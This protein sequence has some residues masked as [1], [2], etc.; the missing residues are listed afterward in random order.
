MPS[1]KKI[2]QIEFGLL[3]PREIRDT[4]AR[5]IIWA[6]TY[7][8]DGFPYPQGLMDL[9]L[10]VIDPGLRCK[11]CDQKVSECPGHFGHIELAKPVIHVGYARLIRK[12]LR[13]TC[14][15]CGRLLLHP[16]ELEL[17]TATDD[18]QINDTLDNHIK[19]GHYCPHC[20][21]TQFK[22]NFEM[23]TT[24]SEVLIEDRTKVEHKLTPADIRARLEKIPNEDL[25]PLGINPDV[26][27]PEWMVLTVLPVPPV[28]MRPSIILENG[29]RS[30]DDLTHKLV[31]IIRINQ[32]FKENQDAGAPQLVMEDLWELLQ[33]HVTTY[34]DNEVTGCP[35]ARHRSGRPLKTLSQRLKGKDGRFRGSL[36]GKRVNFSSRTVISPDPNLS[37]SQVGVPRVVANEMTIPVRVTVY[38]IEESKG[39]ARNGP[40]RPDVNAPCGAN[41]VIRPDTRRLRLGADNLDIV[42]D[43]IEPGWTVERHLQ[44]GDIVLLNRQ[45]SLHRM[46]ILAHRVKIMEGRTFRLNPAACPPYNANFDGGEMNMHVPQTE[47]ARAE[48]EILISV[49][50]NIMSPRFGGPI[51]GGIHDHVSGIFMLTHGTRWLTKEETLYLLRYSGVERMPEPGKI[52]NGVEYWSNKQVFSQILPEHFNMVFHANSCQSCD[53]CKKMLCYRDAYVRIIDGQL[54]SGTIDK[55]AIG[56]FDG[57]I[58]NRIIQEQGKQRAAKFI[59]DLTKLSIRAI[60][61]DGLSF[62]IDDTDLTEVLY[63]QNNEVLKNAAL[64]VDQRIKIYD[65]GQLEPMPGRTVEETLA[66][67]ILQVLRKACD[68]TGQ[69][70][71]RHFNLENSAVLMA[72][73][74]ARGSM[75]NLAQIS[76]CLGQQTVRGE[77]LVYGY[78]DRTLSHF[79]KGD[80]GAVAHGFIQHSF[81]SGLNPTEFFFHSMSGR[82]G[83]VDVA[84][85]SAHSGY[86][87]RR[88]IY[89]LQD[90]KVEYDGT[91]RTQGGRIVQFDYGE[92][93]TDPA[94]SAFGDAV[95]VKSIVESIL[96]HDT[97]PKTEVTEPVNR[98]INQMSSHHIR[99]RIIEIKYT[100]PIEVK[101]VVPEKTII[102]L[103]RPHQDSIRP[104]II[105]E[106]PIRPTI[107]EPDKSKRCQS[108]GLEN[109][110]SNKYCSHCGTKFIELTTEPSVSSVE[111]D[112]KKKSGQLLPEN[113]PDTDFVFIENAENGLNT[114]S[115]DLFEDEVI[116]NPELLSS[117]AIESDQ[118]PESGISS[119]PE[120]PPK[121]P[122]IMAGI[123]VNSEIPI[124]VKISELHAAVRQYVDAKNY[125]EAVRCCEEIIHLDEK[126]AVAWDK[127]GHCLEMAGHFDEAFVCYDIALACN[128]DL[129]SAWFHKG[130]WFVYNGNYD[131]FTDAMNCFDQ[132]IARD[133]EFERVW[134]KKGY[135]FERLGQHRE[136]I[137]CLEKSLA[138]D[139]LDVDVWISKAYNHEKLGELEYAVDCYDLAL[140]QRPDDHDIWTL[141]GLALEKQKKLPEARL[142]FEKARHFNPGHDDKKVQSGS[143]PLSG[144]GKP[145]DSVPQR[146]VSVSSATM[147]PDNANT[148]ILLGFSSIKMGK[149]ED[150][151]TYFNQALNMDPNNLDPWVFKFECYKK[152]SMPLEAKECEKHIDVQSFISRAS[153]FYRAR[154]FERS[155]IHFAAIIQV[156]PA[157]AGL[158]ENLGLCYEKLGK[159]DVAESY[160]R[161]AK[162]LDDLE[163]AREKELPDGGAE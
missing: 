52:E 12:L 80:R 64:I 30:E 11:T 6:D 45:P 131:N 71:T 103:I 56:A 83:L 118:T 87:Q 113:E 23:P 85:R 74:G 55:K 88:M 31:D 110:R 24:F 82:E 133:P 93:G 60:M 1:P 38:N 4:S 77:R 69:I 146:T 100:A 54:E 50:E 16:L 48:A 154:D 59:D 10:G 46:S 149:Y 25:I 43:M 155:L 125:D 141:K 124:D 68:H 120:F 142:C 160:Y 116:S 161:H 32:R 159:L 97:G 129:N 65:E 132:V 152:M 135:T 19:M 143:I 92:D 78:E 14:R 101:P 67:Q 66:M 91:V 2:G 112:S 36:S 84:V 17:I 109:P 18:D 114:I 34:L 47:E 99:P 122:D 145:Q 108:C 89:A 72:V 117:T 153:G 137:V 13:V 138:S 28:T 162:E 104:K 26:A 127:K 33:Y 7:D 90:L 111:P 105:V 121:V 157:D 3:S 70:A 58:I 128:P 61:L 102:Q 147:I 106:R 134:H 27:R 40:V 29:Q 130:N 15:Y 150:A 158:W 115:A 123:S 81:K 73:S 9:S 107:I 63:H 79:K 21:E 163:E 57:Q 39:I 140:A 22:L 98:A 41:Y 96:L 126:N 86:L 75:R 44:D 151:L 136:A 94:K 156:F 5:K 119:I 148:S 8:D 76:G 42:A 95:D 51:I 53:T 35:P 37:I 49:H 139:P 144:R 62:G 20:G